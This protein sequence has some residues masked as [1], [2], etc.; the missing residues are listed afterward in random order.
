MI[1]VGATLHPAGITNIESSVQA[2]EAL[3]PIAGSLA[4]ALFALGIV[5]TGLLSIPVLAG[6]AAYALGE[7]LKWRV[8]LK[9]QPTEGRTFYG[10]RQRR[11][12]WGGAGLSSHLDSIKALPSAV[13]MNGV[14]AVPIIAC[15]M[16]IASDKKVMG[17][18]RIE[19]ALLYQLGKRTGC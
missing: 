14:V 9:L 17:R 15:M 7:A 18:F 13:V 12:S 6:S 1:T 4:F 16:L 8:G 11:P 3:K 2:A 19:G 5:G 10:R